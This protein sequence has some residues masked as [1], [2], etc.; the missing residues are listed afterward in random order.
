MVRLLQ[1]QATIC[2]LGSKPFAV[3]KDRAFA[4]CESCSQKHNALILK[5]MNKRKT[6]LVLGVAIFLILI[7]F[8]LFQK[9]C[10][11]GGL[12]GYSDPV[13]GIHDVVGS[14]EVCKTNLEKF[15]EKLK[16]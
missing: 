11:G 16:P 1:R 15:L 10:R 9:E 13:T 2:A 12:E 5:N 4:A 8:F 3:T 6:F 14:P 7:L